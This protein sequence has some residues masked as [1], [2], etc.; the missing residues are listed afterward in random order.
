[1]PCAGDIVLARSVQNPRQI[2]CK[3]VLGL[4]GDEV[5]VH[6]STQLGPSRTVK[7]CIIPGCPFHFSCWHHVLMLHAVVLPAVPRSTACSAVA[8]RSC[9]GCTHAGAA[10]THLAAGRQHAELDRLAALRPCAVRARPGQGLPEGTG[11][12]CGGSLCEP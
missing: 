6:Q 4:E 2:V 1:M 3:R 7:V 9:H 10:R 8:C 12:M 11:R 5:R